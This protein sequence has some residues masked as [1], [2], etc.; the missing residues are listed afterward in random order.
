MFDTKIDSRETLIKNLA[1]ALDGAFDESDVLVDLTEQTVTVFIPPDISGEEPEMIGH[2]VVYVEKISSH[3]GFE[4]ME[5]FARSQPAEI[6][7]RLCRALSIRHPFR[8][9][10]NALAG[11]GLLDSWYAFKSHAYDD[12]AE[13]RLE[14]CGID[15]EDGKIVCK[16]RKNVCIFNLD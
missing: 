5:D 3:E 1:E 2:E 13:S 7:E 9:F 15:C 6:A 16:D 10:R 8:A 4:I 11:T 14:D 12:I